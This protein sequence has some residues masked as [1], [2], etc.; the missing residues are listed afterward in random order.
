MA[1][2]QQVPSGFYHISFRF[3]G[4]KFKRSLK[5]KNLRTASSR[6]VRLE[7]T[8]RLIE[9]GII[10]L[11]PAVDVASYLLSEGKKLGKTVLV[12]C[13]LS[14]AFEEFFEQIPEGNLELSS[15]KTMQTHRK[16][17]ERLLGKSKY[18]GSLDVTDLQAYIRKRALEKGRRG[19]KIAATTIRKELASLRTVW[20]W[21]IDA[22]RIEP[23]TFPSKG[24]RYPKL[25]ESPPFQTF[26]EVQTRTA[27]LEPQS[28]EARDLWANVFLDRQEVE[29][30]LNLV[31]QRED[32]PPFVYP[33]FVMVAH[34]GARRSEVMRAKVTDL[35][36]GVLT[37]HE[38]K[39][40]R[41]TL[42]TRRVPCSARLEAA[43]NRWVE[44]RPSQ[45]DA[46]FCHVGQ[47]RSVSQTGDPISR[48][49]ANHYFY[50]A[51]SGTKYSQLLG[52]HVFRH[53]F[54]SNC[55][56][57]GVDQRMIDAW[58]GHTT[59]EMRRRYRHLFPNRE[60]EALQRVLG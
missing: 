24:L 37:I 51:I 22:E 35:A 54:C 29:E 47:A 21:A 23:R 56:A 58:V 50:R 13:K 5:T 52:W 34:T 43:L 2:L 48:D 27:R 4:R 7:D 53:S 14:K 16:H 57:S 20:L 10:E 28:A 31:Q 9:S 42:S 1:W 36:A 55:A 39:R 40:R 8:I 18:L 19:R 15:I 17:L 46:M 38:R 45:G 60:R 11:P 12:D 3:G 25:I 59:D 41:G 33:M 44:E 6:K 32:L 30:V 26:S 49:E